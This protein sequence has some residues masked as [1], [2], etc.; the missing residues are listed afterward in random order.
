MAEPAG[1]SD[2]GGSTQAALASVMGMLQRLLEPGESAPEVQPEPGPPP[3]PP[4]LQ[5]ERQHQEPR[6]AAPPAAPALLPPTSPH[7]AATAST[8]PADSS[9]TGGASGGPLLPGGVQKL[10]AL[11]LEV[12]QLQ[13]SLQ[14]AQ[15]EFE[16]RS[17]Q[18]HALKQRADEAEQRVQ[19]A[20]ERASGLAQQLR[21][22]ERQAG[23]LRCQLGEAAARHQQEVSQLAAR[24]AAASA[25]QEAAEQEAACLRQQ[26]F[27]A[28]QAADEQ[29]EQLR[30]SAAEQRAEWHEQVAALRRE[31]QQLRSHIAAA[32]AG[33]KGMGIPAH[34]VFG[35]SALAAA[36]VVQ[37]P[38]ESP[39]EAA[40][41]PSGTQLA[42]QAQHGQL[43]QQAQQAQHGQLAQQLQQAEQQA[44]M[45]RPLVPRLQLSSISL[46][47]L[48]AQASPVLQ[49]AAAAPAC[50]LP[51]TELAAGP[52]AAGVAQ[53]AHR[54]Q[55]SDDSFAHVMMT[56]DG[57]AAL[58]GLA[59]PRSL[60]PAAAGGV[61]GAA[62]LA[63]ATPSPASSVQQNSEFNSAPLLTARRAVSPAQQ[64][65]LATARQWQR[66]ARAAAADAGAA[67]EEPHAGYPPPLPSARGSA[68]G[69][70]PPS[71]FASG[72]TA[73]AAPRG[74]CLPR[75]QTPRQAAAAAPAGVTPRRAAAGAGGPAGFPG[76]PGRKLAAARPSYG[77]DPTFQEIKAAYNAVMSS[78]ADRTSRWA[79]SVF[80]SASAVDADPARVD[81]MVQGLL[82]LFASNGLPIPLHKCGQCQYR[83]GPAGAKLSLR[84]VNGRLMARAG[85]GQ[86]MDILAWLEKQPA[87]AG[88]AQQQHRSPMR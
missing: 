78:E 43:A 32:C 59:G 18:L 63:Q 39:A 88:A 5:P 20:E 37:S 27:A 73:G 38:P 19:A 22:L 69:P 72:G 4:P 6:S 75:H 23:D 45:R 28:R 35:P 82:Q 33:L 51:A 58:G 62:G 61:A 2:G 26:L 66:S 68:R 60:Q 81:H 17:A 55:Q 84:L 16:T 86:T 25:K 3:P 24:L 40:E 44:S 76:T 29:Q 46:Q 83:L 47:Q 30:R 64:E 36:G 74:A 87:G 7:P 8:C 1:P 31:G 34:K 42:Q 13:Q 10:L 52:A 14:I 54:R 70:A 80:S 15:L 79:R 77:Q 85:A 57:T 12:V 71:L 53:Q 56:A 48:Q 50:G 9:G 49:P 67:E 21:Q 41:L 65:L 11:E